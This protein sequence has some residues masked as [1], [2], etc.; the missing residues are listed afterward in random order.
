MIDA[1]ST[2]INGCELDRVSILDM[3]AYED[4]EIKLGGCGA[5]MAR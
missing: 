4:T 5:A 3:D 1:L 2:Y